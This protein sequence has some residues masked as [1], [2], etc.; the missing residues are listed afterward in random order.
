MV[1]RFVAFLGADRN[2]GTLD[3]SAA[4]VLA[5]ILVT[6]VTFVPCF[7]LVFQGVHAVPVRPGRRDRRLARLTG[8]T[9]AL[10][11]NSSRC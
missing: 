8:S 4:G 7:L 5:S 2:A 6:W 3:P 11:R 10:V 9:I 1:V